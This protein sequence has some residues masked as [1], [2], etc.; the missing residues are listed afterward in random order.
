[1]RHH[2]TKTAALAAVIA[3]TL[4]SAAIAQTTAPGGTTGPGAGAGTTTR[5]DDRGFDWGLLGLLG[6][7]GLAGLSGRNRAT[8][9]STMNR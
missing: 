6:L 3:C 2:R 5:T 1:M 9:T 7:I 4:G 8:T